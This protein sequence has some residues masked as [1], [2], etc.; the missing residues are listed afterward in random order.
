MNNFI[1]TIVGESPGPVVTIMG[2]IHGN[3]RIGATLLPEI[4]ALLL[5]DKLKGTVHLILGNPAAHE[6]NTRFVEVDM[7]RLFGENFTELEEKPVV[8]LKKE[9]QRALMIAP[10]LTESDYLLDVHS[11][12]K[13]STPFVY[14][15]PSD[16]HFGLAHLFDVDY[17]V[18]ASLDFRPPDLSSST[19]NFVD[20][21]GGIGLT[22]E[23]GWSQGAQDETSVLLAVQQFLQTTGSYDFGLDIAL[24]T[25]PHLLIYDVLIPSNDSFACAHDF[26]NFDKVS[27]GDIIATENSQSIKAAQ[28]SYII[29]PKTTILPGNVALYLATKTS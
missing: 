14:C 2:S 20:R 6:K 28:D 23:S 29:F 15:E 8:S 1:H 26:S 3:E 21:H 9:E 10:F 18:S 27:K 7:N 24:S 5:T 19:D 16:D 25:P 12:I 13:P 17:V 11:T 22:Y 4:K